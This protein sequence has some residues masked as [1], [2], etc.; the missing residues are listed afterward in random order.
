M[1][2]RARLTPELRAS[3]KRLAET[4]YLPPHPRS[5]PVL[6]SPHRRPAN[7]ER[8]RFRHPCE[9]LEFFGLEPSGAVL[10]YGPGGGFY[11]ELLAPTR[12]N[13]LWL[14]G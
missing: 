9:T 1:I 12:A 3:S 5:T 8:D 4:S 14:L 7:A 2:A 11:T 13:R 6:A 10:E